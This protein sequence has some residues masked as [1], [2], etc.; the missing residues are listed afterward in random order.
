M[1][2]DLPAIDEDDCYQ[3]HHETTDTFEKLFGNDY[4]E[5]FEDF[6]NNGNPF[7]EC[8]Q[9]LVN[10]VS[11]TVVNKKSLNLFGRYSLSA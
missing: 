8:D 1:F 9:D 2:Q 11:K 10:A 5:L 6:H 3:L 4:N 7:V